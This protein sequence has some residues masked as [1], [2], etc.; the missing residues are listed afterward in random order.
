M[1]VCPCCV[2]AATA[3]AVTYGV[4]TMFGITFDKKWIIYSAPVIS[5][6]VFARYSIY[7]VSKNDDSEK[8]CCTMQK[9]VEENLLYSTNLINNNTDVCYTTD[10]YPVDEES[11]IVD[12]SLSTIKPSSDI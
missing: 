1:A 5:F 8:S 2:P 10:H 7:K 6:S 11:H 12:N 4:L 9:N 3:A